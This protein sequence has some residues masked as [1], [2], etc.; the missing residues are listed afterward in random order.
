MSTPEQAVTAPQLQAT[1]PSLD[2]LSVADGQLYWIEGRPNGDVLVHWRDGRTRDVLPAGIHVASTVHEYGG[3]AYLAH[4][5]RIWFVRAEDQRIWC[6][7]GDTMRPV[8]PQ[9]QHGERH[10]DLQV[11]LSD[12]LICVRERHGS[13]PV[14]NELVSLA[15]DG[16]ADPQVIAQGWDFYSSPRIKPDG[17]RLAWL[18]WNKPLM[19]W[20]GAWLWVADLHPDGRLGKPTLVAGGE[21]EAVTQPQWSPDG[22]LHF[23]S[24]RTGWWNLYADQDGH[25]E[26]II[27]IDAELAPAPW[28]FGYSTYQFLDDRRVATIVQRGSQT[29]LGVSHRDKRPPEP[30]PLPYTWIKPYLAI[31]RGRLAVIGATPTRA[32]SISLVDP[33]TAA[34]Q[35]LHARQSLAGSPAEPDAIRFPTRSG[36]YSHALLHQAASPGSGG[37]TRLPQPLLVRPHPGPTANMQLR[38]DP[39][40]S[41]FSSH[42]FAVLEVDYGGS[43]GYGRAYRNSLRGNWGVLDVS[44]CVDAVD[45]LAAAGRIDPARVAICGSSAGGYTALRAVATTQTFSAA[46][47]RH[48]VIDPATWRQAAPKFQAHH[49]DLLIAP[50]TESATYRERSV[51]QQAGAIRAPVL[52]IHG[53]QDTVTPVSEA[54]QLAQALRGRASLITFADEAHGLRRPDHQGQA[55]DAELAHLERALRR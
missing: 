20:D 10:A 44:D 1:L 8:T 9:P 38:A 39:W 48:A 28:E 26:A 29:W 19:P 50:P 15:G 5:N 42:G 45:F 12:L 21:N 46:V 4:G 22:H 32:P 17:S 33:A 7:A 51:I 13:D 36:S 34:I 43:T 2:A 16:S 55:L 24:D 23:L 27:N 37:S 31:D 52:I 53:E 41:F 6:A 54:R 30:V 3:G 11:G 40:V 35:Q 18:T 47:V 49:A 25:A 14:V